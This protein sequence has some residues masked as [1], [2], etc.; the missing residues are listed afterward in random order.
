M[1][2]KF[3]IQPV[4]LRMGEKE[5]ALIQG[6]KVE[7]EYTLEEIQG[8]YELKKTFV[9]DM[10]ELVS[11]LMSTLKQTKESVEELNLSKSNE[12]GNI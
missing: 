5:E 8:I 7:G 3:E 12:E 4:Q 2:F 10:P 11:H 6:I 9:K 1:K